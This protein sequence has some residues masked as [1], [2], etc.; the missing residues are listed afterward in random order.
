MARRQKDDRSER[1]TE[2]LTVQLAPS[3]RRRIEAE[4][5]EAGAGLSEWVREKC[6]RRPGD[7]PVRAGPRR[8]P[9]A[10]ELADELRA[11]GNNLNQLARVA[12][13]T[14]A[15]TRERQLDDALEHLKTVFD[16]V[17]SL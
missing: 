17:L 14:G 4:A 12:N 7:A 1:L 13:T 6:L 15:F 10:R 16:R 3:E 2:K 8:N 11:I 9:A 5:A